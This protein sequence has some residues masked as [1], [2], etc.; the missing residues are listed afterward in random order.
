MRHRVI[1]VREWDAQVA[2]FGCCGRLGGV[3]DELGDSHTFARNRREMERM[4]AVY[5]RLR[6][7]FSADGLDLVVVD[8][9]NM[10]WLIPALIRDARRRGLSVRDTWREIRRGVAYNAIVVDGRVLFS[11]HIPPAEEAVKAVQSEF[12]RVSYAA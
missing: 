7:Q 5:R 11:G 3:H 9:R 6:A 4:G 1:L 12:K 10:S 2:A 8:P